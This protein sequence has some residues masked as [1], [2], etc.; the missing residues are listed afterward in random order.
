[1]VSIDGAAM[2]IFLFNLRCDWAPGSHK[3]WVKWDSRV[4]RYRSACGVGVCSRVVSAA[5][6]GEDR[7]RI[8]IC[9][10]GFVFWSIMCITAAVDSGLVASGCFPGHVCSQ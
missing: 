5:S 7:R 6:A 4:D 9:G 2:N 1:M 10:R 3:G 8:L